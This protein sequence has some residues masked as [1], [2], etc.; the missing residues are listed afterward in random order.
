[1][2]LHMMKGFKQFMKLNDVEVPVIAS[3][4]LD[5]GMLA[6]CLSLIEETEPVRS[7]FPRMDSAAGF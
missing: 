4:T 6:I 3:L 1:M 2:M 7:F 5:T